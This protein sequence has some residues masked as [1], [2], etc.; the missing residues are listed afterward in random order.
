MIVRL[1]LLIS[2]LITAGFAQSP[3]TDFSFGGSANDSI[4]GVAID[5]AQN[6]YVT[7]TTFSADLPLRNASQT[8]N[9]GTQL[10]YSTDAGA[11]WKPLSSP[12]GDANALVLGI[13]PSNP[14]TIYMGSGAKL[15][16]S[17]DGGHKLQCVAMPFTSTQTSISTL[18]VDPRQPNT[19]YASATVSGGVFKS[20]DGGQTWTNMSAGLPDS[21]FV[22]SIAMDPFH[23]DVLYAW[24]ETGGY[25]SRDGASSWTPSSLPWSAGNSISGGLHF[26][27][28]P[29]TPGVIYGPGFGTQGP[30]TIQKSIDAGQTWKT[31]TPP[32]TSCCVVPDPQTSGVLYVLAPAGGASGL[33]LFWKS[34]DGGNT[35]VS[36]SIPKQASGPLVLDPANS[37]TM[38]AG[39]YRS[40]DG[41]KT[42]TAT[43]VSRQI[44]P[45]FA[46]SRTE[47]V[48]A[49]APVTSDAFLAKFLPDGKTLVFATYFG[50][51]G[52]D[53]A[54]SIA[55]DAAGN[56]W[57]AGTTSSYDLP[58][59]PGA[60]QST[61]KGSNSGYVAKFASD[62]TLLLS[63]YLGGSSQE[64]LYGLAI[65]PQGNPWVIGAWSS[66][67]FPFTAGPVPTVQ[68]SSGLLAE[69][70]SSASQLLFA[71]RVDGFFDA[72]GKGIAVDAI[73]NVTITGTTYDSKFPFSVSPL[74]NG[75]P[76][77]N[78]KA[79][80]MKVDSSGNQIYST[81]FGGSKD[82]PLAGVFQE[83]EHDSGVAVA[84]DN[85]GNAYIAGIT[86]AG[87]FPVTS[88]SPQAAVASGCP[89]PAFTNA[90][91][92][93]GTISTY[94]IDD[95]F[96]VKLSP[97]GKAAPYSALLGGSCYDRPVSIALDGSGRVYVAGE[98]D[99]Q[100]FPLVAPLE[101]A[102]P[103]RQFASFM[104][105]LDPA[106]SALKFSTYVYAGASPS[107]GVA[108]NG[109]MY[110]AG[111]AGPGAQTVPDSGPLNRFPV[112]ATDAYLAS[113]QP[114][115][116][117]P[118]SLT[119]V[120]NAFSLMSGPI[121]PGEIVALT[122]PGFV[123]GSPA[124]IG[125]NVLAP[126]S[127]SLAGVQ[128]SFDGRPAFLITVFPGKIVCIAPVEL[129]GQASTQVQVTVNGGISNVLRVGVAAT[130]LGLLSLD[131]SG[132]GLANARNADGS[133]NS[134]TNPAAQGSVVTVFL[135]GVGATN[136]PEVDGVAASDRRALHRW[137]SSPMAPLVPRWR[138]LDLCRVSSVFRSQY[139]QKLICRS[140]FQWW[141][142]RIHR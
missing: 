73:G 48:Y 8:V 114:P 32:F 142:G 139:P 81:M 126:L 63:S 94:L 71:T 140:S 135:T 7:G 49:V 133:L 141:C 18:I 118:V 41:G 137:R 123:P 36:S 95:I 125:L 29:V 90:T 9:S 92:F 72:G 88:G 101:G 38:L 45:V 77:F 39:A 119:Q 69:L 70:D 23:P 21:G 89:Y 87:G 78:S 67:D 4:S 37:Q 25:V 112:T 124:D 82:P 65:S 104:T 115:Q 57:I 66:S 40:V 99:S 58:V 102:P 105:T 62:G 10:I 117:A 19:V 59:T 12:F 131:G 106:G 61:L 83:A 74:G 35:W 6:I 60:Y 53:A 121:A 76:S 68:S 24:L 127:T 52:T 128:V 43:N 116:N 11:S 44:Q 110:V 51:M 42:W 16:K 91:G 34:S 30:L 103:Y 96:V 122:L 132:T 97:D 47:T 134:A 20:V 2:F 22:D 79:F 75:A 85:S 14:S 26:S 27:F 15:C 129:A 108:P 136:P 84:V 98:T 33:V 111:S 93:I 54:N 130:S 13:D 50:G 55:L 120:L 28:D 100:D 113:I 5:A 109:T 17:V 31:L 64:W 86:S 80:V 1:T 107:I 3:L 138:W 56:V 46:G